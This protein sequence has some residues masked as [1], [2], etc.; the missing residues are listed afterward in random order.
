MKILLNQFHE[1]KTFSPERFFLRY[2]E[3]KVDKPY[4]KS[5]QVSENVSAIAS[6]TLFDWSFLRTKQFS[7][8]LPLE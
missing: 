2:G 8:K 1:K 7:S 3:W 4:A 5:R 6:K